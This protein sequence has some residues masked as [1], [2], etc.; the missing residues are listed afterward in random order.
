MQCTT[1]VNG[2]FLIC[3]SDKMFSQYGYKFYK[4]QYMQYKVLGQKKQM[5]SSYP[6]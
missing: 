6:L 4:F 5:Q 1:L 3:M 2:E